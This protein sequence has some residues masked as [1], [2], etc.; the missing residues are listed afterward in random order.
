M[1]VYLVKG[2][3]IVNDNDDNEI[4]DIYGVFSTMNEAEKIKED[5]RRVIEEENLK[6]EVTIVEYLLDDPAELYYFMMNG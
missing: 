1:K 2:T 3:W 5:L 6:E 4:T